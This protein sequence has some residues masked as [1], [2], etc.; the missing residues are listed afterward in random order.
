M[1]WLKGQHY[2]KEKEYIIFM[3][4]FKKPIK[5]NKENE[6]KMKHT[7]KVSKNTE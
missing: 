3:H 5:S 2:K 1:Y 6:A 4:F 7:K